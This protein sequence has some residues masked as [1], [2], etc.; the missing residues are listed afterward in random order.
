MWDS[1]DNKSDISDLDHYDDHHTKKVIG[2]S[3]TKK[4]K[5]KIVETDDDDYDDDLF[6]S[7]NTSSAGNSTTSDEKEQQ[8]QYFAKNVSDQLYR[9]KYTLVLILVCVTSAICLAV[10]YITS[11]GEQSE[12]EVV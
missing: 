1:D 3:S 9:F 5:T 12:F 7:T 2:R 6:S 4:T 8:Q 10:Y 11:R